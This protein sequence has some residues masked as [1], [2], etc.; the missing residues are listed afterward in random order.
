[1]MEE[2]PVD[3]FDSDGGG[4]ID[5]LHSAVSET[6]MEE[7]DADDDQILQLLSKPESGSNISSSIML[8]V[9]THRLPHIRTEYAKNKDGIDLMD[10]LKAFTANMQLDDDQIFL[11]MVPDLVDFF[12]QV[13]ING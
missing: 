7:S 6:Q 10:F 13:D 2:A 11:T 5:D 1:M 9:P 12:D 3:A 4:E 8:T